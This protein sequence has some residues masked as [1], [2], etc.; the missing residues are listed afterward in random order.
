MQTIIIN[1]GGWFGGWCA[2]NAIRSAGTFISHARNPPYFYTFVK[3]K[4]RLLY[5]Y[6]FERKKVNRNENNNNC[7]QSHAP[8]NHYPGQ[9]TTTVTS[10]NITPHFIVVSPCRRPTTRWRP[11]H[12]IH[13]ASRSLLCSW[14]TSNNSSSSRNTRPPFTWTTTTHRPCINNCTN[15]SSA[16]TIPPRSTLVGAHVLWTPWSTLHI[17]TTIN[18]RH[19]HRTTTGRKCSY[20]ISCP[21]RRP[22]TLWWDS[23]AVVTRAHWADPRK[24]YPRR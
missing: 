1:R 17:T 24:V 2:T 15:S 11:A 7:N 12:S 18:S 4:H 21:I 19:R 23:A 20:I 6:T 9:T 8:F 13:L 16:L 3:F 14:T 10:N 5:S 22:R